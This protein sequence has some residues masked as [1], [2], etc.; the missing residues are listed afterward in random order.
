MEAKAHIKAVLKG[1]LRQKGSKR[2]IVQKLCAFLPDGGKGREEALGNLVSGINSSKMLKGQSLD[3]YL[4]TCADAILVSKT[5]SHSKK[6]EPVLKEKGFFQSDSK[7][8]DKDK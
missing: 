7:K 6:E 4:S 2:E 5:V 1:H 8:K 3:D